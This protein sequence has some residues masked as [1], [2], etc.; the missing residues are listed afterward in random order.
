[1]LIDGIWQLFCD[2]KLAHPPQYQIEKEVDK[3]CV[4]QWMENTWKWQQL[5][6]A[7][8]LFLIGG[9]E[10]VIW[11]SFVRVAASVTGH[12]LI[13]YFA[14]NTGERHWHVDGAAVQ[15]FNIK[16]AS[17]L[18]MGESYHNNHLA[19]PGSALLG[20][21]PGEIDPGW[22]VI[23]LFEELGLVWDIKLPHDLPKRIE[24]VDIDV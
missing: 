23:R 21:K 9:F 22:W 24:L 8:L 3:D 12:W 4:I 11:G 18:T 2:L 14:H 17:L 13:G 20:I 16:F 15:G 19:Y 5:P 7:I 1:M 10:W 6:L